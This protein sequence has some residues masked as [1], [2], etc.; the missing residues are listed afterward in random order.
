MACDAELLIAGGRDALPSSA[1]PH[2]PGRSPGDRP[3]DASPPACWPSASASA[4]RP[5]ANGANAGRR[6]ARTIAA[7]RTS[8]PGRPRRRSGPSSAPCARPP[9]FRSMTSPSSSRT[10]CRISTAMPSTASSRLR[11]WDACRR[12]SSASGRAAPSR[13]TI[14]ASCTWTSSTCPSCRPPM[15][16][17][18][19]A[20]CM[21]PSTAAR[22]GCI[23]PSRTTSWPPARSPS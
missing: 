7:G 9:A 20:S 1:S 13:T 5:S 2:H 15:A 22:A 3:L 14:S 4:P 19:S 16:S 21:S 6:T 12:R 23:W 11:A 8:C 17:A 10:S 18:A